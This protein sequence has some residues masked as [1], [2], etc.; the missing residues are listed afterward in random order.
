[1]PG[2]RPRAIASAIMVP[3]T[4]AMTVA[5][6][7]TNKLLRKALSMISVEKARSAPIT[8]FKILLYHFSVKPVKE[9]TDR[10][11]LNEKSTRIRIGAQRK[12]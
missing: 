3:S 8:L 1:M 6:E 11:S 12:K 10:L 4:V 7:P 2:K 9:A 5:T